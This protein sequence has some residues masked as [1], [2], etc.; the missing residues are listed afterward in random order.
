MARVRERP[1]E[2]TVREILGGKTTNLDLSLNALQVFARR[3]L[4]DGEAPE[5]MYARVARALADVEARYG[6]PRSEVDAFRAEFYDVMARGEFT[7]A[8][9][10]L[11]NAGAG[12][13]VVSNCVVLHIDDSMEGIF[14]TLRDATLLQKFGSGIGFPFHTLRPAGEP[15]V[16]ARGCAS[17]PVSFMHVYDT[18]FGVVKQQNRNGANMAVLSVEH[19]DI[20]E[21][22]H[23]KQREGA[24]RNFNVSVGL[25]DRF[26]RAVAADDAAPWVCEF[27]GARTLP[28]RITRDDNF[29]IARIE[30][31]ELTARALFDEIVHCAWSTGEPGCVFLDTVNAANPLPGLGR[32]ESCNPCGEQFLHDGDVCNLGSVNLAAFARGGG[33]D[34]ARLTAVVRTA[35]RMLDNV[36]DLTAFPVGRVQGAAAANRRV[37]IGIMGFA[38]LLYQLRV[39]YDSQRARE[40][41]AR[42]MK[43]IHD[44]AHAT[45]ADLARTK[46]VFPNYSKSVYAARGELRR[47]AALTNVAPTGT[48]SMVHDVSGG[49]E[50]YFALAYHYRGILG[51]DVQLRYVNRHLRAALAEHGLDTPAVWAEVEARGTLRGVAGVP[52]ALAEVFV[53]AMDISA[54]DHIRMQAAFQK[55]CDNAISK[56][57]NFPHDASEAEVRAGYVAAWRARCKGCTVYRDGSRQVQVL[58]LNGGGGGDDALPEAARTASGKSRESCPDCGARTRVAE[59]CYTC[60]SC[61]F[62]ACSI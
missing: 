60:T 50:P 7:P 17:G 59:G 54:E 31:V 57:I 21:F 2:D 9:R 27:G 41:A 3:Y 38:D 61:A 23:C 55:H 11:A 20:L 46:G 37:G 47:N 10:T 19:P 51:G 45:S 52:A 48:I 40:I 28:R 49:V 13:P 24:L 22:V 44:V 43:H 62:S 30:P 56:T 36:I 26:M 6:A 42:V 33:V 1:D 32:I 35:T 25:T 16:R 34:Y 8:G 14:E 29:S 15:T 12:T 18:A 39:A 5:D 58:N 4:R 53:T